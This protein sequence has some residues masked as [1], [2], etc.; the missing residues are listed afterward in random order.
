MVFTT[1]TGSVSVFADTEIDQTAPVIHSLEFLD[2]DNV[3]AVTDYLKVKITIT[4]EG[5]GLADLTLHFGDREFYYQGGDYED[6][7]ACANDPL[8]FTG[9]HTLTFMIGNGLKTGVQQLTAISGKDRNGNSFYMEQ[10]DIQNA[11][12]RIPFVNV[13]YS[14]HKES[15]INLKSFRV[16]DPEDMDTAG[17]LR[18]KFSFDGNTGVDSI[19]LLLWEQGETGSAGQ[20]DL[21]IGDE[22]PLMP[23]T[24]SVEFDLDDEF[25]KGTYFV[26]GVI[27]NGKHEFD[28]EDTEDTRFYL[29]TGKEKVT[30]PVIHDYKIHNQVVTAP[31]VLKL[32]VD[33]E[34]QGHQLNQVSLTYT[35]K[36]GKWHTF[37]GTLKKRNGQYYGEIPVGPFITEGTLQLQCIGVGEFLED[38]YRY[39]CYTSVW[40]HDNEELIKKGNITLDSGYNITYF[41]SLGNTKVPG[42]L[43]NMNAG[44]TAVLDCRN[45]KNVPKELFEAIAG[46]DVTVAFIDEKVQWVFNGKSIKKS[47]CKKINLSSSIKVVSGASAGFPDDKKVAKLIFRNNG[48][49]PGEVEM[50]INYDYLATKYKFSKENLKLTYLSPTNPVLEDSNVDV[51]EDEYYE[52][53]VDHNSTFVLS[54]GKAKLGATKVSLVANNLKSVKITWEKKNGNGYYVYRATKKDG[55][56]KKIATIKKN[57]TVTYVDKNITRG[58]NYYYKVKPYSKKTSYNKTAKISSPCKAYT[59]LKAPRI[60]SVKYSKK[61]SGVMVEWTYNSSAKKYVLYRAT[62]KDGTYKKILTTTK[63]YYTDKKAK[64]DKT[65]YYKVKAVYKTGSKMNSNYSKIKSTLDN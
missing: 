25:H 5:S 11:F 35:D 50:R 42:I 60:C 18:V 22:N 59:K 55:K 23:G 28:L 45:Y 56:Y 54:K 24:H 65:Y 61:R 4:E 21:F 12:G 20:V 40:I 15:E 30:Q 27:L 17:Q 49:L 2:A 26:Y 7:E 51:A 13:T 47:K 33:V 3:N 41:G 38:K 31:E 10:A 8:L 64:K 16:V 43:K 9:E 57:S 62:K 46:R 37:E 39:E 52:Y 48:E 63:T 6:D 1:L 14:E 32:D 29:E 58:K 36:N 44:E 34:D 53:E 19:S